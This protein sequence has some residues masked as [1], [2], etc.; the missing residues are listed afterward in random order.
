VHK[1]VYAIETNPTQGIEAD[2]PG[3]LNNPQRFHPNGIWTL[4]L[5]DFSDG[6][7]A[8]EATAKFTFN[9][10]TK[11]YA[12]GTTGVFDNPNQVL[13]VFHTLSWI[14]F[15]PQCVVKEVVYNYHP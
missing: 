10:V 9:S 6:C 14:N 13:T 3:G 11:Y 1:N 5:I 2:P 4:S 8:F 7:N 12:G 15:E